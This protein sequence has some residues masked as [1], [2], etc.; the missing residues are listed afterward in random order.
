MSKTGIII[1]YDRLSPEALRKLIEEFVT[2]DGTDTGYIKLDLEERA[3]QVMRQI[4]QGSSVI[5]FDEKYQSANI[6]SR[7]DLK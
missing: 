6:V 7:E 4:R 5:V 2:R 3:A 1:P